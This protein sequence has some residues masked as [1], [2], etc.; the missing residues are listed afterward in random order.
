LGH[1]VA[2]AAF[3]LAALGGHAKLELDVV[4]AHAGTR[5]AGDFAVGDPFADTD[6]HG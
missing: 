2:C 4:E 6:N 5:M 3:A 1:H